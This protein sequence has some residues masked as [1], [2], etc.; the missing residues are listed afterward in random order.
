VITQGDSNALIL[1]LRDDRVTEIWLSGAVS[2]PRQDALIHVRRDL[3]LGGLQPFTEVTFSGEGVQGLLRVHGF[4]VLY[5]L[6]L[7]G[8]FE[9]VGPGFGPPPA[10]SYKVS[11]LPP[12]SV[13]VVDTTVI[14]CII[15]M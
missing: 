3:L 6:R 15:L 4:L 7:Y 1:A 13:V 8:F 5:R 12:S 2:L 10:G 11:D 9:F 14:I